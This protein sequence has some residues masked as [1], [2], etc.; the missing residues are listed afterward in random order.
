LFLQGTEGSNCQS[1]GGVG[2]SSEIID[3]TVSLDTNAS[4]ECSAMSTDNTGNYSSA[5]SKI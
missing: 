5:S 2:S 3:E 1:D 4:I